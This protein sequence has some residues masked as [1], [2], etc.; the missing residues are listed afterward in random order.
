[1]TTRENEP[2]HE[3]ALLTKLRLVLLDYHEVSGL[4]FS[5]HCAIADATARGMSLLVS[6]QRCQTSNGAMTLIVLLWML[7]DG[8]DR[9]CI[10]FG[11][12]FGSSPSIRATG[13]ANQGSRFGTD[14]LGCQ[15]LDIGGRLLKPGMLVGQVSFSIQIGLNRVWPNVCQ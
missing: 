3:K 13:L 7:Y 2:S 8:I 11:C 14:F 10:G 15:W 5:L 9:F 4:D 12:N 6:T 1:M